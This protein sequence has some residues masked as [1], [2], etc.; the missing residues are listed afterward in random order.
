MRANRSLLSGAPSANKTRPAQG[1]PPHRHYGLLATGTRVENIERARKLLD[2]AGP[3]CD[4]GDDRD[5]DDSE[6]ADLPPCPC[7]GSRLRIIER[8]HCGE[9]PTHR[10]SPPQLVFRFDTS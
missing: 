1:L 9:T 4:A 10:P 5:R 2:A 8:F 6:V 7:C 3:C